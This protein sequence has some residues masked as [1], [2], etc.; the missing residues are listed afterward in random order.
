MTSNDQQLKASHEMIVLSI[1]AIMDQATTNSEIVEDT[2]MYRSNLQKVMGITF[3]AAVTRKDNNLK[4]IVNFVKKPDRDSLKLAYWDY[5]YNLRN[6]L[7][8]K[9]DCLP[10]GERIII[11]QQLRQTIDPRQSSSHTPGCSRDA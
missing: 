6:H 8:V 3:I 9:E 7:H 2:F 10:L 1:V 11:P 5:W 4:S